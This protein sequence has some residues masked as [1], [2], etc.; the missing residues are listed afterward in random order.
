MLQMDKEM[1]LELVK[2]LVDKFGRNHAL[3]TGSHSDYNETQLR[4]DFLNPF[5]SALGWDVFNEKQAPQHLREV[6]HEDTV[7]VGD[8]DEVFAKKP[9]YALRLGAERK[10]FVE[11]KRPSV[12]VT[13]SQAA[14]FQVRRYGWNA[15]L[16][17]SVLGNFDK[18][19][20]YDCCVRPKAEDD[21]RVARLKVYDYTEYVSKF[22]EIYEQLSREAVYS[23]QFDELFGVEEEREGVEPFDEYFLRQIEQWRKWLARDILQ[24]NPTLTQAELNFLVQRLLNRIIFLR[25]CEDRELEKY[26]ALQGI[27]TYNELK[28][29][30][31][32]AD[33]R[34]NSGLFDFIED[35]L[36]LNI[37]IG[38]QVLIDIFQE[39]YYPASPFAFSVVQA[40][41]LGE[42]YERF[43]AKQIVV[44]DNQIAIT[45]KDEVIASRGVV[46][47]PKYVVDAIVH[48]TLAPLCEGK[49]P[50]ELA[51]LCIADIACGSGSFLV[52]AYEYLLH[53]YLEWYLQGGATRHSDKVCEG[54]QSTWHLTLPE[55]QRILCTHI[56][57]VDIDPQAVEI[58]RFSLLLKVLENV[59]SAAIT[60]HLKQHHV[61]VLPNLQTNIQCGNSLVDN[62]YF[63]YDGNALTDEK[64]FARL[65][66]LDWET[67]FP[68]V[69]AA[70][71]FDAIAGNPPYIRI[72]NM[73]RYS[74]REVQYYQSDVSPYTCA[75]SDN[76]DKYCLFIERGL[77]LLK[78]NG[79][80]GYIVP[81]KFFNIKSGQA[82]RKL[83]S[84][85]KH[86][87][88]I[89][90]FGVQQVFGKKPT[91]YTCILALAKQATSEFTVEHVSNLSAWRR[92][93]PGEIEHYAAEDI[94]D[95]PW[96]F[97]SPVARRVFERLRAENPTTLEQ[98]AR[99]FV[100]LQTSAD[101]IY[102]F[103][104]TDEIATEVS[105]T[106]LE[107]TPWTI[108]KAILRPCLKKVSL[109]AFSHP[110]PNAYIIF[111]YKIVGKRA[112]LY[113]PTEMQESFPRCWEYL[114]AHKARLIQRSIQGDTPETWYRY[115]RSQSLTKFDGTPKLIWSVLTLE[116]RYAYDD[117]NILF[118]GGGNGPYYGLRPLPDTSLSIYYLQAVLSHP[119]IDAMVRARGSAFRDEYKS[120]GKQF[121]RD[122]PI[123]TID[124]ANAKEK[125]THDRIVQLVK[126]LI[127]ATERAETALV[128]LQKRQAARQAQRLHQAVQKLVGELYGISTTDLA[129]VGYGEA[130]ED[131]G[132]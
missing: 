65:N 68:T 24:H 42:I 23:G 75:Q 70:G 99:I 126:A 84:E 118:T 73:V 108:E 28:D 77:S 103:E 114:N 2:E 53:H 41:I 127:R 61:R 111:P 26:Q 60:A 74:P 69:F 47:T 106:D 18:L 120:H 57:G 94:G 43:L 88:E 87:A 27:R 81:H 124:F 32:Q 105:F 128:P 79:R 71:G 83:L 55:R 22:N 48:K 52:A 98:V 86:V 15:R 85:G 30:F 12:P 76:F 131:E 31:R 9:D 123:R 130:L 102:I 66:P 116:G 62:A 95:A 89:V 78:P 112:H 29:I 63:D 10:F 58:A 96:E 5:L 122:L 7:E 67:A 20:I 97:V 34:Y 64:H 121:V 51:Q 125:T 82:L 4:V 101:K 46:P 80:L 54:S 132:V 17:I 115:G 3:Y 19:V 119:V 90:H 117:Q 129:A 35:Q 107:G 38:S 44:A 104:P 21:V 36:S 11:A 14:A 72:Q 50:D 6:V 33:E 110:Q 113:S 59:P 100:G 109:P 37:E 45:E 91:T 13:T 93:Q 40:G 39:L 25:I 8:G 56:F 1:G 49:S 92:G 16:S